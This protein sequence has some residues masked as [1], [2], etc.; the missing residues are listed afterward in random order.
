MSGSKFIKLLRDAGVL[1]DMRRDVSSS[2]MSRNSSRG[3]DRGV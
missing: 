3:G 1:R 2:T